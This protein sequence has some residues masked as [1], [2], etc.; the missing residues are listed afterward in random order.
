MSQEW[1]IPP[2]IVAE[3]GNLEGFSHSPTDFDAVWEAAVEAGHIGGRVVFQAQEGEFVL[4]TSR[5]L[6]GFECCYLTDA[7]KVRQILQC[8][9]AA[10]RGRSSC[11]LHLLP[12]EGMSVL[13]DCIANA[14][15]DMEY[16][17]G[18]VQAAYHGITYALI[19]VLHV[20]PYP[21]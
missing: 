10:F 12:P 3:L 16:R 5:A 20:E 17:A 9:I 4:R 13:R 19:I 18:S 14:P 7:S 1:Q 2:A 11:P 8:A 6:A 15:W 21:S